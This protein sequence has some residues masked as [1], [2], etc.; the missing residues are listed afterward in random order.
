MHKEPPSVHGSISKDS[1]G[2]LRLGFCNII[3][4]GHG[5]FCNVFLL[6]PFHSV[7]QIFCCNRSVNVCLQHH[8]ER[9]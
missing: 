7:D 3:V 1:V 4:V 8:D 5:N 2:H 6:K 9:G